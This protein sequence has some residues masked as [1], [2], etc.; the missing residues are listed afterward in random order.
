MA[1]AKAKAKSTTKKAAGKP[2]PKPKATAKKAAPKGKA[3]K[4]KPKPKPAPRT[5]SRKAADPGW[6]DGGK[7]YELGIRDGKVVARKDGK[8]LSSVPK[9]VKEGPVGERLASAVDFLEEHAHQCLVTVESWMLRSLPVP[10]GVL[11]QV[12]ADEAWSTVLRDAWVVPV[13]AGTAVDRE[14]G[15]FFRGVDHDKGIGAVNR[16]GETVW[17]DAEMVM[18]PHPILLD[19]IEDLRGMAT[20]IG[21]TQGLEQLYRETYPRPTAPPEHDPNAVDKYGA[22]EFSTMTVVNLAKRL[23]YR[24]SGGNAVCRVL[25]RG[26][27]VEAR[28]DLGDCDPMDSTTTGDLTWVDDKQRPLAVVDV[29]PVAFSEGM[30]MASKIWAKRKTKDAED[31]ND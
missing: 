14:A 11:E 2:K 9:P 31:D 21:V 16:D 27:F 28:Y 6:V 18:I 17:I 5:A 1:K 24:V 19:E 8:Q 13:H 12:M 10:R 4:G 22:G 23:G 3:P 25:E 30:R 26:K 7:G 15:G 20:E 29:S